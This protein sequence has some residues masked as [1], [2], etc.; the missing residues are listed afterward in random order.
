MARNWNIPITDL[1]H[2]RQNEKRLQHQESRPM[3][4]SAADI[5]GPSIGPYAIETMNWSSDESAF[6]GLLYSQPG[7]LNGPDDTK[8]WIGQVIASSDGFGIQMV[9]EWRGA[10]QPTDKYV[11]EFSGG[12]VVRT[13]TAWVLDT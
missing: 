1:D 12:G 7:A 2:R 5:L 13:Y 11:R 6:N 10:A 8:F 9:R 4:R 3:I